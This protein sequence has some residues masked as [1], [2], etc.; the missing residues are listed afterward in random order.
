MEAA[1]DRRE[2]GRRAGG[3]PADRYRLRAGTRSKAAQ[4]SFPMR[5]LGEGGIDAQAIDVAGVDPREQRSD[6]GIR[7]AAPEPP[8]EECADRRVPF[9]VPAREQG[10]R[11]RAQSS[12]DRH[13]L[14]SRQ[15]GRRGRDP[16]ATGR[17]RQQPA[18]REEL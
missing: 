4:L 11:D 13:A 12:G 17:N 16:E 18:W 3:D 14:P 2:G 6:E 8:P 7:R 5:Q 1:A 9:A 10:F 15:P